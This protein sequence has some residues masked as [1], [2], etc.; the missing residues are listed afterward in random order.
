MEKGDGTGKSLKDIYDTV[1]QSG[2]EKEFD[3]YMKHRLNVDRMKY[4]KN[5]CIR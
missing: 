2:L 1:T 4:E 5:H 3:L